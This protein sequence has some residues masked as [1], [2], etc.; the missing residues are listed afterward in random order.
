M[1]RFL[2]M[3]GFICA[4]VIY[5][6]AYANDSA[7]QSVS[8][9]LVNIL[10]IALGGFLLSLLDRG[11]KVFEQNTGVKVS[12]SQRQNLASFLDLG[13]HFADEQVHK[14]VKQKLSTTKIPP[15]IELAAQFI[16]DLSNKTSLGDLTK[17][18]VQNLIEARLG[19]TRNGKALSAS[20]AP[21]E[22]QG[23]PASAP[24]SS[25]S[26]EVNAAENPWAPEASASK[27]KPTGGESGH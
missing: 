4:L 6:S 11:I 20:S 3:L 14:A 23:M 1:K 18:Q 13:I 10:G 7:V 26:G 5:E 12:E 17:A 8:D 15:K 9:Q 2:V 24:T 21:I 27:D 19:A 25:P 16:L 22:I